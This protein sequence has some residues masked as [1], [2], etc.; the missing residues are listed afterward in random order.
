MTTG[1]TYRIV[2]SNRRDDEFRDTLDDAKN[3]VR[4]DYPGAFEEVDEDID[5]LN[6]WT[7][8]E[9]DECAEIVASIYQ[10]AAQR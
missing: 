4:E 1:P 2:W 6:L 9:S 7:Y 10:E 5:R 8:L 3:A